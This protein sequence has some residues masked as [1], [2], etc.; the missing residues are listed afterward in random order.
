MVAN[1]NSNRIP[2]DLQGRNESF[3]DSVESIKLSSP[4][5]TRQK[6]KSKVVVINSNTEM[7]E[8]HGIDPKHTAAVSFEE[9]GETIQMEINDGGAAA[10]EFNSD[11]GDT[12]QES[13]SDHDNEND[14]EMEEGEFT[15]PSEVESSSADESEEESKSPTVSPWSAKKL[16]KKAKCKSMEDWLDT[17][18]STLLAVTELISKGGIP[19]SNIQ[20]KQEEKNPNGK[21]QSDTMSDTTIYDNALQKIVQVDPEISFKEKIVE[22]EVQLEKEV[23][24]RDSTSSEEQID[25]SDELIE[26]DVHD[27]FIAE[28]AAEASNRKRTY[29]YTDEG[30]QEMHDR[31]ET[32]IREAEAAR[33]RMLGTPGKNFGTCTDRPHNCFAV[34]STLQHSALVDENYMTIGA[35]VDPNL[36]EKI[37]KGEYIDFVK[38]LPREKLQTDE[39][40]LELIN[41]GGQTFFMPASRDSLSISNFNR[42]EQAFRVFS[43][44]YCKQYPNK[45]SELIQY[46]HIIYTALQSYV[47]ENVYQYDR[48]FR[49]HLSAFPSRS[50]AIILQQAWSMCLKDRV[51]TYNNN[52]NRHDRQ[53]NSRTK[54]DVCQCFN[55]GLCTLGRNCKYDHRCLG[56]GK[57]G[58]G[59]HICRKKTSGEVVPLVTQPTEK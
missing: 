19:A 49:M 29:P 10:N 50:W 48:E 12:T 46:N 5:K 7:S 56:C 39:Q 20:S 33:I 35:Y 58:H 14:T 11:D 51:N 41:K 6:V 43:N 27:K 9:E 31:A 38:L 57:F 15:N 22:K 32:I 24:K 34:C 16:K 2:E 25:T 28:C 23:D 8:D 17:L 54:K 52:G 30:G 53:V 13:D 26:M 42:W 21:H 59:V 45:S 36:R 4:V 3:S 44:I 40:K 18:S 1:V 37:V 55:K 47:W